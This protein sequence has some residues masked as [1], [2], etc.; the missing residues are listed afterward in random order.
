MSKTLINEKKSRYLVPLLLVLLLLAIFIGIEMVRPYFFLQDDNRDYYL[1]YYVHNY[2]SLLSGELAQYN[3]HQFMGVPSL[4]MGQ[5]GA[6]YPFT[7]LS[8]GLSRLVFGHVFG[9]VEIFVIFHLILAGIGVYLLLRH[10]RAG[11]GAAF[12]G[13]LTWPLSS[14]VVFASNSWVIVSVIAAYFPLILL[15][16]FCDYR[17]PSRVTRFLGIVVRLLLFYNGHIQ[18]FIYSVIFEMLTMLLYIFFSSRK[19][20][21]RNNYFRFFGQFF[22]SYIIVFF[23]SLPLLLPMWHVTSISADRS[24]Q[25]QLQYYLGDMY[26]L[27]QLILGL[28]FPFFQA[29]LGMTTACRNLMNLSHIG[30][31]ATGLATVGLFGLVFALLRK[32]AKET[33]R[34]FPEVCAYAVS[35]LIGGLWA[36]SLIFNLVVYLIPVLN[37]FRWSFKLAFYLDFFLVLV[38]ASVLSE[39]LR[40]FRGKARKK[41]GVLA[42]LI[43][44]Q[45][46]NFWFMYTVMPYKDFGEHHADPVPLEEPIRSDLSQGRIISAAFDTWTFTKYNDHPYMTG[47]TMGFNYATLW[48]LDHF[49]GYE[50]LLPGN[51][52]IATLGLNFSAILPEKFIDN[53]NYYRAAGVRWYIVPA[54]KTD[55]IKKKYPSLRWES[56]MSDEFRSVFRDDAALPLIC[57]SDGDALEITGN[58]NRA[59]SICVDVEGK[60][61]ESISFAYVYDPFIQAYADNEPVPITPVHL[62]RFD[63]SVPQGTRQIVIR[64]EDPYFIIGVYISG[65]F[66][67]IIGL[68]L[69]LDRSRPYTRDKYQ[70]NDYAG[71]VTGLAWTA[72]GGEILFVETSLSRGKEGNGRNADPGSLSG[73]PVSILTGKLAADAVHKSLPG[74]KT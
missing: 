4:A 11:P 61:I 64:Y 44:A 55:D 53:L 36:S 45:V 29:K 5:T 22:T 24:A 17:S 47:P 1:P 59:N 70:G 13:G 37:R 2:D 32:S 34:K 18:Y 10:F 49:A 66:L 52:A 12:F 56:E 58:E 67:M 25:L 48:K 9:T 38:A 33:I 30:Y 65:G 41:N 57:S 35:A 63:V 7:Y 50:P 62:L 16:T 68:L 27:D 51:N 69:L 46:I 39:L 73:L 71:A 42:A 40:R 72:V 54:E 6:L 19:G 74:K 21:R 14:F 28:F 60:R 43:V 15:C 20:E 23:L 31:A 8:L 26:P 3:F